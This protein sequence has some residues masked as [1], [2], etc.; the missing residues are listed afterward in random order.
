MKKYQGYLLYFLY[1]LLFFVIA[2]VA[3]LL[4]H[5]HLTKTLSG[6]E[7]FKVFL[8]GLRMDAAFA[9]YI[10]L[11]PFLLFFIKSVAVNF[12]INKIIRIYTYVLIVTISFLIIADLGL[13]TAWRYRMD[14]TPLQYFKSPKEMLT[15]VSSAPVI[16]LL[17]IFIV[18]VSL[19]IFIYKK[20]FNFFIDRKQKRFHLTD[21]FFSLF[22]I[23]FLFV[24]IRGGIQ[25]IPMII[26]DVYFSPKIYADQAAINLPWNI[27]FSILNMHNPN[28]PFKYFSEAKSEQLVD[29]LY[30]AGPKR[31]PSILSVKKPN[32]IFIILESFTAKWVGCLGGVPGVTPNLDTIAS[33]GLLFTHIYAAGDRSEKGQ[34]AVLSGY[35]NQAITS[36]VKTPTKTRNLPSINQSL[37]KIGYNSSYTYGGELSFANIKSYLINIGIQKLIGKYSFPVS[38]RTTSWGV[39]DQYV[40]DR[41]YK[42]IHK[43]KQP[44]FAAMFTL[45]SHEPYDVPMKPRFPGKDQTTLFENSV[46]YTDSIIGH[47]I[48]ILKQDTL[49]KNTL[50]VF[51]ADHGHTLPGHDSNDSPAKFRIPLIFSG[52]ALTM[53]GKINNIGSQ[54]D[55]ATTVLD[56]LHLSTNKFKWG[57]DLLDTSA[58][59]FAFY[60]F[61]NGFG[62][63]TPHGTETMDN[64][65][66]K[67][68]F[69]SPGY[70]TSD[71][72]Y[73]KAYMQ[74]SY[75]D[76]LNR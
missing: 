15:T 23:T 6:I 25:K 50:I 36:I 43:D 37:E 60:S 11:L 66:R 46:Y 49:W 44:F 13:Y 9:G 8:Y 18:L 74:L 30:N 62:F 39:H 4:Y 47:F 76:Y 28:N 19:Y 40:F 14:A 48:R 57:K 32:I 33:N 31:I 54:T 67:P 12:S 51:V 63:V 7:I 75:Q 26:S 58:L 1:W 20:Y 3:F 38:E 61:N 5:L 45:S 34:V 22:L 68:I 56:Q 16:P 59:Q 41:F 42:D 29:S 64:V 53:N 52:G 69:I 72:N 17:I 27:M 35:P 73:G 2:K 71:I 55:I 24:P 10:C 21:S 70:D 65:S